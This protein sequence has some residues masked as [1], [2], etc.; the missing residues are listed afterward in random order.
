MCLAS[1]SALPLPS[2][3]SP[4]ADHVVV[5]STC[6]LNSSRAFSY[7]YCTYGDSG[8][9]ICICLHVVKSTWTV[10]A[11]PNAKEIVLNQRSNARS[12]ISFAKIPSLTQQLLLFEALLILSG[13]LRSLSPSFFL[14]HC[15]STNTGKNVHRSNSGHRVFRNTILV[16]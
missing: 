13:A 8:D 1:V 14:L 15:H 9:L 6:I 16:S 4:T 3:C 10:P 12:G 5:R 7:S 11:W 2:R